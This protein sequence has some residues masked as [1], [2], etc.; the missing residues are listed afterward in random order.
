[1][2]VLRTKASIEQPNIWLIQFSFRKWGSLVLLGIGHKNPKER[3][4]NVL[5]GDWEAR[6]ETRGVHACGGRKDKDLNSEETASKI[7]CPQN[8]LFHLEVNIYEEK[9]ARHTEIS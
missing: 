6:K 1:M 8:P 9:T 7:N 2:R 4:H 5:K 3:Q